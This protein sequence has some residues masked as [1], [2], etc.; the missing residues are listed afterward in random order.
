MKKLLCL[1][2]MWWVGLYSPKS[3]FYYHFMCIHR[4]NLLLDIKLG[5][6]LT[7][8]G[9]NYIVGKNNEHLQKMHRSKEHHFEVSGRHSKFPPHLK[10]G[11]RWHHGVFGKGRVWRVH[12]IYITVATF[13][14]ILYI[15][16][17]YNHW[18]VACKLMT[19]HHKKRPK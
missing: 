7:C 1:M 16:D 19:I 10:I 14:I 4:Q 18:F 5:Q 11:R 13:V 12:N 8:L 6:L 3:I 15:F 2:L 17:I 9:V